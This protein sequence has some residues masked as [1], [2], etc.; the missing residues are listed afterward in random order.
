MSNLIAIWMP[1]NEPSPVQEVLMVAVSPTQSQMDAPL[2]MNFL[3]NKVYQLALAED[4]EAGVGSA[5]M[6]LERAPGLGDAIA[7]QGL[8]TPQEMAE[9]MPMVDEISWMIQSYPTI[10]PTQDPEAKEM[11]EEQTLEAWVG[12]LQEAQP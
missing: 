12:A 2:L 8:T 7:S 6:I 10:K 5:R 3:I 1:P 9:A 11:L 4:E